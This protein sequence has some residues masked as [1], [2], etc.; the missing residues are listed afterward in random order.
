MRNATTS[1]SSPF[2]ERDQSYAAASR[3][4]PANVLTVTG[5]CNLIHL[6]SISKSFPGPPARSVL[7]DISLDVARGELV[8]I[9]G[10][11]GSGKSTLLNLIAGLDKPDEGT[12]LVDDVDLAP[13]DDDQITTFRRAKIGFVFQAFHVLPY[14]NVQRNAGLPLALLGVPRKEADRRVDAVLAAVGMADRGTSMPRELSGGELQ[15]VAIARALVH[16]PALVLADEPTGNLDAESAAA[17]MSLLQECLRNDRAT[18]VLV[19]HSQAA[20]ARADRVFMLSRTGLREVPR[21]AA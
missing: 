5:A 6:R 14:L 4:D 8:A 13:L 2:P 20:A 7:N 21:P 1:L 17:V 10:E 16:R 9:L 15:R 19:T 18:G 3:K 12:V 11:S